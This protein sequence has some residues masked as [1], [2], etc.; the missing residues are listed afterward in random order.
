VRFPEDQRNS[1]SDRL[2]LRI[3]TIQDDLIPLAVSMGHGVLFGTILIILCIP[4][5]FLMQYY[6]VSAFSGLFLVLTGAKPTPPILTTGST[7]EPGT[8]AVWQRRRLS[9]R[10][11]CFCMFRYH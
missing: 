9:L 2:A 6:V 1:L 3:S 10:K 11:P 4:A 8:S 7:D 5:L